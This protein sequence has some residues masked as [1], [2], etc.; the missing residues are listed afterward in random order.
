MKL[1]PNGLKIFPFNHQPSFAELWEVAIETLYDRPIYVNE[2]KAMLEANGITKGSR[3][4]D[5]CSGG[6]F[7]A[8]DLVRDGYRVEALDASVDM[9]E[10]YNCRSADLGLISRCTHGRWQE[11]PRL[12]P[13][14]KYDLL[15]CRGNSFRHAA[16]GWNKAEK[17]FPNADAAYHETL[18]IFREA[19]KPGGR[20]YVDISRDPTNHREMICW[21]DV[22]GRHE[23]LNFVI[24]QDG[25]VRRASFIRVSP[26]GTE[27][28]LPNSAPAL[29]P[30]E[31]EQ[32]IKKAGF[33][34]QPVSIPAESELFQGWMAHI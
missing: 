2:F 22:E 14:Q 21:I 23:Q 4:L 13:G 24:E 15:I 11:L 27:I 8:L 3:I 16:G 25:A 10:L 9:V 17:G 6:G 29:V 26:D 5:T 1:N 20:L 32:L 19:L 33:R 34:L 30:Y 31:L 7:P 12:L 18:Q 28:K